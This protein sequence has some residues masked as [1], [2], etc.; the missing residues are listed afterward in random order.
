VTALDVK[1]E[2][3]KFAILFM[4]AD[5]FWVNNKNQRIQKLSN[6]NFIDHYSHSPLQRFHSP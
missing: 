2:H 1:L 5:M 3:L 6:R 4:I